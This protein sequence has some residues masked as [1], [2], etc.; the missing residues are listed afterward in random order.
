MNKKTWIILAILLAVFIGVGIFFYFQTQTS[1]QNSYDANRTSATN[2]TNHF[3][4][5][6]D[7][8]E[9]QDQPKNE[10][11]QGIEDSKPD[12]SP[13]TEEQLATFST[14]IYSNDSARQNNISITCNTLNGTIVKNGATFSFCGTVGQSS[15]SKG[16]QKADIFDKDGNKKKGL[17]GGNCQISSTL[18][19]AILTVPSLVVTERHAHSNYVPYIAKGKDAAVAYR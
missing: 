2:T 8:K 9:T 13:I 17:G 5:T 15:S 16:Y 19:N 3:N 1:T 14:K 18:Y 12:S 11:K 4:E 6:T 10:I 7:A